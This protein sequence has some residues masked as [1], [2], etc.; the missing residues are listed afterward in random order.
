M[1]KQSLRFRRRNRRK[2]RIHLIMAVILIY[3][4]VITVQAVSSRVPIRK[5]MRT[6]L[7]TLMQKEDYPEEL[8]EMLSRNPEMREFVLNY[9]DKK[10]KVYADTIREVTKGEF[11][12]LL[13]WDQRWGYG[14]YGNSLIAVS[15]CGPTA[16]ASVIAGLTGENTVT[17][18]TIAK[19]AEEQGYCIEGVGTSW[20]LFTS[21]VR[22]FGITGTE[23]SLSK[24]TVFEALQNGQPIICSMRPGDFTTTGHFIT[25]VGIEDGKIKVNDSNSKKNSKTLWEYETLEPQIKNL[26]VFHL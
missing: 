26:W 16:L 7:L 23:M 24:D 8:L 25:L 13:Q 11:P 22:S 15:G 17:P 5:G 19:F 3:L 21:G 14:T 12:L 2:R 9:P 6:N 18:Y 4:G 20:E 10:G 1:T